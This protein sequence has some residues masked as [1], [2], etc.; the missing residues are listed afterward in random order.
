MKHIQTF[1]V[2]PDIPE[3]LSFLETL[4]GN[5]WWCWQYDAVDLFHRIEPRL[6][7]WSGRNPIRFLTY[8]PQN[9]LEELA[10]DR[11]F[12]SHQQRVRESYERLPCLHMKDNIYPFETR[13]VIA[14]FS[15]EFGIHESIPL[16]AGGLGI[17]AGD[18]L[19]TASDL[20]MPLVGVGLLYRQG[21]FRQFLDQDGWQQEDYPETDIYQLPVEKVTDMHGDDIEV[22][23]TG[24]AGEIRATIWRTH[25]GC[26][27]LLLLDTNLPEN[28]PEIR[29]I[30]SKLYI[31]DQGMRISQEM[32]LG[33]GGMRALEALN[34][35][36]AVCHM[37][38]GHSAFS[39][40]ERL[41]CIMKT[42]DVDLKTAMEIVP[43]TTVFTT[44]T[45]VAAGNEEFPADMIRPFLIPLEEA[46]GVSAT[47][48]LSWGQLPDSSPDAPLSMFVLGARMAQYR[49]GVSQ[50]HGRVARRMWT[51]IWPRRSEEE[52]P[53]SHVTNGVHI[54][55]FL[56]H[57]N[58]QLFDRYI[59][60]DWQRHPSDP[61][62]V[63]RIDDI[64][65][66]ELWRAHV[67]SRARLIR[68]CRRL[69]VSQYKRRNA[70]K[71][72]L[73]N[74]ELVLDQDILTIAFA[75][76]FATYKRANLLLQDPD[77]FEALLSSTTSPVQF[78]F[79][80]KAHPRDH[81][82]KELIKRLIH[83]ARK[84][85]IRNRIIFLED[86]DIHIARHLVHGADVWLNTPRRPFEACGT[87]GMKAAINGVLNVSI[88]DGW[89]CEGYAENRGWRIGNGEEYGD[90]AYQDAVE[91]RAL[92]NILED[93][94]LP[95]FY[96]RKNGD[97]PM[98]W[99]RMM[100][101]SMKMG[102]RTFCSHRMVSEYN[103]R[104]YQPAAKRLHEL[105]ADDASEARGLATQRDRIRTLWQ[106]IRVEY[107]E[108][109]TE[110]AFRVGQTFRISTTV[111]LG[112]LRP[113][114]VEV[115]LYYGIVK[116]VDKLS[117]GKSQPMEMLEAHGNGQYL[118]ACDITCA[119]S[120]RYGFTA[121]VTP[122]GDD[123]IR[124]TP[125]FITWA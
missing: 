44:H 24:P 105:L 8:V 25:V 118:Y 72:V 99:V 102:M 40:L 122:G 112:E 45:P 92:Y 14:Y 69:M 54:P 109:Q 63:H 89:W 97:I 84:A 1:Q 75:R 20:E 83:F 76:R 106:D 117:D 88:L 23:V 125:G 57:E 107:P 59:G 90:P 29:E 78:I 67:M 28:P 13:D 61:A 22:S 71:E 17:L 18:H 10:T 113:D 4:A 103:E 58:S 50:L 12:L 108:R 62:N 74:A 2:L 53:I 95:C 82:G 37:N 91:S 111:N 47:E 87:S 9:R 85:D 93:E 114:D 31:G 110:G 68:T 6:W 11:S 100:K 94:V 15:M 77:R 35:S 3:P 64:Y 36:P 116:G 32:V 70:P 104:F 34:L 52:T 79:A 65:D 30:T 33:I 7:D 46:L 38:E 120:G 124:F 41:A 48:I 86:Y 19:K 26:V 42:H 39:S 55:S 81:E 123:W 56:S 98:R 73:K 66:E 121:R 115:E 21:Y 96:D 51:H 5:I 49:N 16:F 43:R 60:P 27:P 101:E 80:G 119:V